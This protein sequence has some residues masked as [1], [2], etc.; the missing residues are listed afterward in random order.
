MEVANLACTKQL[1][2][3]CADPNRPSSAFEGGAQHALLSLPKGSA[4]VFIALPLAEAARAQ[5]AALPTPFTCRRATPSH[6]MQ[7]H[8]LE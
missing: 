8:S 7:A 3:G 6:N 4:T 1:M 5:D 2:Q